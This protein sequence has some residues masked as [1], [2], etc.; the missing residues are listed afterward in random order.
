MVSVG[1]D[2]CANLEPFFAFQVGIRESLQIRSRERGHCF[3]SWM[4]PIVVWIEYL[5]LTDQR[6]ARLSVLFEAIC[7][8]V[9]EV[10][11]PIMNTNLH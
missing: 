11:Q 4:R 1:C 8:F 3:L 6:R 10:K 5:Q 9:P 2:R 7:K